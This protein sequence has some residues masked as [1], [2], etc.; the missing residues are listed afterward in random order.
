G[1][2]QVGELRVAQ[3]V[4]D[5]PQ[6]LAHVVPGALVLPPE[7]GEAGTIAQVAHQQR[8]VALPQPGR[9][10]GGEGELAPV[11]RA[12]QPRRSRHHARAAPPGGVSRLCTA[13][14]ARA[15]SC[16]TPAPVRS[17][18]GRNRIV[19]SRSA[20]SL[21]CAL[22]CRASGSSPLASAAPIA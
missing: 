20:T 22:A 6:R 3:P 13:S 17:A 7:R 5:A 4:G 12:L 9:P 8:P 19:C 15:T 2:G 1:G 16:F 21:S 10:V 11:E 18:A 14:T